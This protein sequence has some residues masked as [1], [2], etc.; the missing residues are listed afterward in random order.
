MYDGY[1]LSKHELTVKESKDRVRNNESKATTK[2]VKPKIDG[3]L[4]KDK[5]QASSSTN[6]RLDSNLPNHLLFATFS[7]DRL[8]NSSTI[9]D[10]KEFS[11]ISTKLRE[12]GLS[13]SFPHPVHLSVV[14][15]CPLIPPPTPV[16]IPRWKLIRQKKKK[17]IIE[18]SVHAQDIKEPK[19][20]EIQSPFF[21]YRV[22]ETLSAAM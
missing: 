9:S 4:P 11:D 5:V 13:H 17:E 15:N 16:E 18:P 12:F 7:K 20:V 6:S 14:R 8:T 3:R 19:F 21:N 22:A 1:G 2:D 10:L